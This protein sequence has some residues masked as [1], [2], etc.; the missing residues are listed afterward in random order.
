MR[1]KGVVRVALVQK[2]RQLELGGEQQ[3]RL[4]RRLLLV[5]RREHAI[6]IES[7]LAHSDDEARLGSA[8]HAAHGRL[9]LRIPR[10]GVVR[11]HAHRTPQ[12][13]ILVGTTA[14]HVVSLTHCQR[15]ARRTHRRAGQQQ[16]RAAGV[17]C[18]LQ[19]ARQVFRKSLVGQVDTNVDHAVH[20]LSARHHH[21]WL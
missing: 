9:R 5:L 14:G 11:M 6:E 21:R 16:M 3:L 13:R 10:L 12:H 7:T 15:V 17:V 4:E 8:Q 18:A 1:R 19:H 20:R 2:E